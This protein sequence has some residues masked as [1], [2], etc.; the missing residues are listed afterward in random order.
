M[1]LAGADLA[2]CFFFHSLRCTEPVHGDLLL[3]IEMGGSLNTMCT[4]FT[5]R[6]KFISHE[7]LK[8]VFRVLRCKALPKLDVKVWHGGWKFVALRMIMD[9]YQKLNVRALEHICIS[10]CAVEW[11]NG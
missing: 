2:V 11:Q 5:W 4:Y 8:T 6:A 9:L 1:C 3:N 10:R 7:I